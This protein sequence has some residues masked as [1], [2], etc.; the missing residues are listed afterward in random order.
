M[1]IVGFSPGASGVE[2]GEDRIRS[3]SFSIGSL[4]SG[5]PS[6]SMSM[7]MSWSSS[8]GLLTQ[9]ASVDVAAISCVDSCQASSSRRSAGGGTA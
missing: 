2:V 3:T 1:L 6:A 5:W 4:F 8:I 7:T 9:V